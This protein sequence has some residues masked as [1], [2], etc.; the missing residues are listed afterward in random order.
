MPL[1]TDLAT[2]SDALIGLWLPRRCLLCGGAPLS[3][4]ERRLCGDCRRRLRAVPAPHGPMRW[5]G[6][7]AGF[8]AASFTG[9]VRELLLRLKY[10]REVALAPEAARLV[11][12]ARHRP[13]LAALGPV[14]AIVPVPLHRRRRRERGFNQAERIARGVAPRFGAPIVAAIERTRDTP[15][16]IGRDPAARRRNLR[17]AFRPA[18]RARVQ[19]LAVV[20]VDDVVT[21]GAT[22]AAA[23]RALRAAG[24]RRVVA[25][26][27]AA[28]GGSSV[29]R[30]E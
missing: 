8:A 13:A 27:V 29:D 4:R 22:L 5:R 26:A 15:S 18:P 7:E 3:S 17:G 6:V 19:G 14:D 11:F 1:L 24:A 9:D 12:R 2:A 25:L 16:Q 30:T 10:R 21:T 20:V 28:S 23:A